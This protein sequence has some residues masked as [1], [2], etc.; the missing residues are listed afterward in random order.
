[1]KMSTI[2]MSLALIVAACN[3][4]ENK[5]SLAAPSDIKVEQTGLETVRLT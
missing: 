4:I 1:M 3:P 5:V 2:L